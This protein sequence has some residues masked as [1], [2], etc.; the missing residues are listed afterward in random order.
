MKLARFQQDIPPLSTGATA[1]YAYTPLLAKKYTFESR[2]EEQVEMFRREGNVIHLPRACC[3]IGLKDERVDGVFVQFAKG[4]TPKPAQKPIFDTVAKAI[5]NGE[6]GVVSA[7]TGWGKTVLG[8][9][10]AFVAQRKTLVITTKDDIYQQWID[11]AQKFLGLEPYEIGEIRGDKCEVQGTK[12]CV[13]MIHSLSKEG[14]Y[15]SWIDEEF[16]L[17]IV[18][19][20]HRMPADQFSAVATMFRAKLRLGLSATPA[21]QD[22]KEVMVFCHI[23]PII[24]KT[25]AEE[26]VPK[27]LRFQS[28]WQCPRVIRVDKDTGEKT[29][30]RLPHQPGKTAHIEKILAADPERNHLLADLIY[31]AFEKNRQ[32]AF[33][34]TLHVHM[35][36]VQRLLI[37]EFGVSGRKVGLYKGA[38]NKAEEEQRD[39]EKAKPIILTTYG[40]MGEGTSIDWLDTCVLGMPR[41]VVT[42]PV[43]RVRR[44][45]DSKGEP[46]VMDVID[47]DS[48]VFLNYAASRLKWYKSIGATIKDF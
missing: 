18:D 24:A 41:S 40:M 34:S 28:G 27:V 47:D 6:S 15:P 29:T 33:F 22:G 8:Y 38:K 4:P 48:P 35:E 11:G 13:A 42:Q 10:A 23:G 37:K 45:Y 39:R 43:G 16:G 12:F 46:V 36:S 32:I 2:F 30:I 19:E 9:H 14:K 17:V 7:Y 5:K 25:E 31:N 44:E 20:C 26:L 21:R 3:P 1:V